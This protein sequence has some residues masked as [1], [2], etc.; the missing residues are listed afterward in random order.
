[1]QRSHHKP[2]HLFCGLNDDWDPSSR[3]PNKCS[4]IIALKMDYLPA[5][6]QLLWITNSHGSP[7]PYSRVTNLRPRLSILAP[8]LFLPVPQ[9]NYTKFTLLVSRP[10]KRVVPRRSPRECSS[11]RGCF[12]SRWGGRNITRTSHREIPSP[13]SSPA[14]P[15]VFP[16]SSFPRPSSPASIRPPGEELN[17]I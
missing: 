3:L 5:P 1:M 4:G 6:P 15:G 7:I 8:D 10:G 2:P 12:L 14:H 11:R 13:T 17:S 16:L 9:K